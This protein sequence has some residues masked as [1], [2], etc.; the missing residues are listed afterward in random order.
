MPRFPISMPSGATPA[1]VWARRL[2][3][4][5]GPAYQPADGTA[6]A[7]DLRSLGEAL[8][9][10]RD[11]D[12]AAFAEAFPDEAVQLLAEWEYRLGLPSDAS[13]TL[14]QR[15]A[16]L[17]AKRR[18]LGAGTTVAIE[19][20]IRAVAPEASALLETTAVLCAAALA[21][22]GVYRCAVLVSTATCADPVAVA[23]IRAATAPMLPAH[24]TLE[25]GAYDFF[26]CDDATSL[27][28][29]DLLG[30]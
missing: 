21:P 30:S 27:T 2:A 19:R 16:A 10:T 8:A 18:S 5:L 28:D 29:R 26:L 3:A 24:T 15:H 20:A 12:L 9:T 22:R 11:T 4:A 17:R 25:I 23:A 13:Q 7:D 14:A 6:V 1:D